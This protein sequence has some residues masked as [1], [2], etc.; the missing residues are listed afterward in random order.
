MT[1]SKNSSYANATTPLKRLFASKLE[2]HRRPVED[3]YAA[4]G[5]SSGY[6]QQENTIWLR[7]TTTELIRL[8]LVKRIRPGGKNTS[9][10]HIQLTNRGEQILSDTLAQ[11]QRDA[12][13]PKP[14]QDNSQPASASLTQ[15]DEPTFESITRDIKRFRELHD[16][17]FEL[18]LTMKGGTDDD[19]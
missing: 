5:R 13:V 17:K 8:G 3:I 11:E 7:N 12:A 16:C 6:T 14:A 9:V 15:Q 4:V 19:K 18:T 2:P 1:S 10:T